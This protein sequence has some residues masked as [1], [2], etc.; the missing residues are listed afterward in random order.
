[1]LKDKYTPLFDMVV[2]LSNALDLIDPVLV[3]HHKKVA[4]IAASIAT[5][6]DLPKD[7]QNNILLA[8]LLHDIGCFSLKSRLNLLNP[9]LIESSGH[10]ETGYQLLK[11]F[12]PFA[13]IATL[14]RYHDVPWNNGG[15]V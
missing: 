1:M 6:A 4:Y 7:E 5:H 10:A 2:S 13:K 11:D 12:A 15:G 9:E 14:I 8:G 3:N